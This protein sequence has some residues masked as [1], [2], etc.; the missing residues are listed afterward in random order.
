MAFATT[1]AHRKLEQTRPRRRARDGRRGRE[2]VDEDRAVK[3]FDAHPRDRTGR[4]HTRIEGVAVERPGVRARV[5]ADA[6]LLQAA[7]NLQTSSLTLSYSRPRGRSSTSPGLQR[8]PS[9]RRR[10]SLSFL[11]KLIVPDVSL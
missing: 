3:F 6:V 2:R 5:A 4:A 10:T 7:R 11:L 8:F 9:V 1:A